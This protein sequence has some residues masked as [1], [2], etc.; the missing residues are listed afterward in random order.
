MP[1]QEMYY[2]AE[3]V[4]GVAVIISIVFVGIELRQ[5]TYM[6]RKSMGEQREERLSWLQRTLAVNNEF[7]AFQKRIPTEW[8]EFNEDERYRA[9]VL[10]VTI[11]RA[12]LNELRSYFDGQISGDELR[13][14]RFNLRMSKTRPHVDAAYDLIKNNYSNQIQDYWENLDMS[15]A[16]QSF[17]GVYAASRA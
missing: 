4:V 2:I 1:L 15:N 16:L 6:M 13:S 17:A 10:G 14:L 7:R 5:N 3:M 9:I 11:L 8:D 12:Q